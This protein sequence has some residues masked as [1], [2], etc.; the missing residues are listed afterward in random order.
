MAEETTTPPARPADLKWLCLFLWLGC[1]VTPLISNQ[2]TF[3]AFPSWFPAYMMAFSAVTAVAVLGLWKMK[4]WGFFVYV[5]VAVIAQ[6][7]LIAIGK[8]TVG[9]A[10]IQIIILAIFARHWRKLS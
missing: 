3:A 10:L 4:R 8:W 2:K 5:G 7:V 9:S 6:A 1:A